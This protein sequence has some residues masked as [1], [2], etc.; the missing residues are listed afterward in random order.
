M[1]HVFYCNTLRNAA[2]HNLG[3]RTK[4]KQIVRMPA[5]ATTPNASN[6]NSILFPDVDQYARSTKNNG[7]RAPGAPSSARAHKSNRTRNLLNYSM[8][9]PATGPTR[10]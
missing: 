4:L 10:N 9:Q 5:R 6:T 1:S 2:R 3:V 7:R 8:R